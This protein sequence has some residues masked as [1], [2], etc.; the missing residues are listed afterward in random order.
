[1]G[2]ESLELLV[3]F[4]NVS[5]L[6]PFRMVLDKLTGKFKRFDG[7]WRHPANYWFTLILISEIIFCILQLSSIVI[8][9]INQHKYSNNDHLLT[10]NLV[11]LFYTFNFMI[12]FLSLRLFLFRF[13][14]FETTIESLQR[15]DK[16]LGNKNCCTTR[17]RT[18]IGILMASIK[19]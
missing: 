8:S 17:R 15:I 3:Q 4:S 10:Y 2:V 14:H 13:R 1:M 19:V 11:L 7:H 18:L 5:A 9:K 16:M 6:M 12:L